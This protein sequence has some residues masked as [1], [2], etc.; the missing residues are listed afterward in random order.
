[1]FGPGNRTVQRT[2][3]VDLHTDRLSMLP[4]R[5]PFPTSEIR[6]FFGSLW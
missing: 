2:R 3:F 6:H 5:F 4:G 1:M